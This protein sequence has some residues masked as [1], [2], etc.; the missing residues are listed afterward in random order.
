MTNTTTAY[1]DE[2]RAVRAASCHP[3][4]S[5]FPPIYGYVPSFAAGVV[6]CV[7][8]AITLS[9]HIFQSVRLRATISILLAVGAL[10]EVIGWGARAYNAKCPY[11]GNAFIAQQVTLIIAPVFFA[12]ALYVLLGQLILSLGRRSSV[13]TAK[14]YAITF[15]TSDVASLVVQAVGGAIASTANTA[16]GTLLGTHIMVGGIA[17]QLFTMTLFGGL[18]VD[19]L[20]RV[21]APR[22]EFSG[23]VTKGMKLVLVA[24]IASFLVI[25]IRSIYRTIELAQGWHGHLISHEGY[26]IG[27][28]AT[29]MVVAVAVFMG[30]DPA[31]I[32]RGEGRP[33]FAKRTRAKESLNSAG[34][35][36]AELAVR[37][38]LDSGSRY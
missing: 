35:S 17:F 34:A 30:I 27:L 4:T 36:D 28:D 22:G 18:L 8:F 19:F 15:C 11:N 12:A 31:V 3:L 10:T 38:P 2:W 25:Y 16:S 14:W 5:E 33:G 9:Y 23:M 13:V 32:F 29:T 21:M 26:F 6:F 7:L 20:V 37:M 1:R 24:L